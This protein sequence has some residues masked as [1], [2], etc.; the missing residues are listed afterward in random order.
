M[1]STEM[2]DVV[3]V[4]AGPVGLFG[5]FQ[6]G[7][8]DMR[9]VVVDS[10]DA[11]G[12]QCAALYPDKPIYDIPACPTILGRDLV[13]RLIRQAAPFEPS[14]RLGETVEAID[15]EPGDLLSV[16]LSGGKTLLAR[17][18]IVAAGAGAMGPNRPPL[19]GIEGYEPR[20]V[21]Y[22]VSDIGALEGRR[23]V[24]A[25]GGDSAVDWANAL[26]GVAE[27]I[28]VVHRRAKFRAAPASVE[29]MNRAAEAGAIE[30][31]VPAQL[32]ALRGD[33]ARLDA[34]AVVDPDGA[35]RDLEADTLLALFGLAS[36][37]GPI[38]GWGLKLDRQA[39]TVSPE[40]CE[41][42]MPGVFAVGD[43]AGYPGKLKLIL[44][45][46]AE[47]AAAAHAI[48]PRVHPDETLHFEHSTTKGIPRVGAAA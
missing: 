38:A 47:V 8:L 37:L 17:A 10:L 3:I 25:G 26:V 39:I 44:T 6:C 42:S 48:H 35:V 30:L 4:G 7:M 31:V 18:V 11:A 41:T 32:H 9:C 16:R 14:Y 46:F 27:K 20:H 22:R 12:G 23:V 29:R 28:F 21:L 34:I 19:A 13:D 1:R 15:P 33:G 40:T 5:V 36:H 2:A 43:I 24:V 45:G